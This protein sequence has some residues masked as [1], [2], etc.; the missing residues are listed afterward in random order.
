MSGWSMND[1]ATLQ[2]AW[3]LMEIENA[4]W[5]VRTMTM[6]PGWRDT[7][8]GFA[9]S[10]KGFRSRDPASGPRKTSIMSLRAANMAYQSLASSSVRSVSS[11]SGMPARCRMQLLRLVQRVPSWSWYGETAR[12]NFQS[13]WSTPSSPRP[14]E[15]GLKSEYSIFA[16]SFE[17]STPRRPSWASTAGWYHPMLSHSFTA[18]WTTASSTWSVMT[19]KPFI[20]RFCTM[21]APASSSLSAAMSPG[22]PPPLIAFFRNVAYDMAG[23]GASGC[24][25]R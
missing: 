23:R 12:H 11:T 6:Q 10:S 17:P 2:F 14:S 5:S 15:D 19:Q 9:S 25:R 20:W 8:I 7:S 16:I 18:S 22:V 24:H 21:L 3:P 13:A 4:S 1:V